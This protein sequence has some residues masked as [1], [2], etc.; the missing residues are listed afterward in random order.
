[1]DE[2]TSPQQT[3]VQALSGR[4]STRRRRVHLRNRSPLPL[5]RWY[6]GQTEGRHAESGPLR[7]VRRGGGDFDVPLRSEGVLRS[8]PSREVEEEEIVGGVED[9]HFE[10]SGVLRRRDDSIEEGGDRQEELRRGRRSGERRG[11]SEGHRPQKGK[12]RNEG[13]EEKG[14]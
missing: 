12:G 9:H 10:L 7:G 3:G 11:C 1:M 5:L 8:S 2:E 13:E 4:P 6:R 14:C